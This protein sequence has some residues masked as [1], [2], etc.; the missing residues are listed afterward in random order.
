MVTLGLTLILLLPS[1]A[2]SL[3][4]YLAIIRLNHTYSQARERAW[5]IGQTRDVIIYRL[6]TSATIEEKIYQRQVRMDMPK[7]QVHLALSV[8]CNVILC[9]EEINRRQHMQIDIHNLTVL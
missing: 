5:R 1:L 4:I 3:S 2:C 7:A 6:M 9:I 8:G